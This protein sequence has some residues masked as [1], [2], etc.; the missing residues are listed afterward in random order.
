MKPQKLG[1]IIVS[2]NPIKTKVVID[3][4]GNEIDLKTKQIIKKKSQ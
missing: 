3:Q 2:P 1:A 4:Y